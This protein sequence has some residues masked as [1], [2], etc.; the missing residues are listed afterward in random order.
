MESKPVFVLLTASNCGHCRT[1]KENIWPGLK[2][3]L[4]Q[5]GQVRVEQVEIQDMGAPVIPSSMPG[6]LITYAKWYPMILLV[7]GSAWDEGLSDKRRLTDLRAIVFNA[8]KSNG[9]LVANESRERNAGSIFQWAMDNLPAL[10][11]RNVI[12]TPATP[13]K[14]AIATPPKPASGDTCNVIFRPSNRYH[15]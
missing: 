5:T 13:P 9:R 7:P 2:S 12:P 6:G 14:P 8:T 3:N 1:F 11:Q 15:K 10:G 4:L